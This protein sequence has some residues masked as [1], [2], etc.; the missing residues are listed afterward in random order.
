MKRLLEASL[1]T[2]VARTSPALSALAA[3]SLIAAPQAAFAQAAA[4]QAALAQAAVPSPV[5]R[6]LSA[7]TLSQITA[8]QSEANSRTPIQQ[9]IGTSL[10]FSE[11][12][13]RGLAVAPGI[14]RLRTDVTVDQAGLT[15]VDIDANVTPALLSALGRVGGKVVGSSVQFGQVR[16]WIPLSAVETLA[17]LAEVRSINP[18]VKWKLHNPGSVKGSVEATPRRASLRRATPH[19]HL[20]S[21]LAPNLFGISFLN[22]S[23]TNPVVNTFMG[24]GPIGSVVDEADTTHQADQARSMFNINGTGIKI[25]VIS[26]S[27]DNGNG[28]YQKALASGDVSAVTVIPGQD[29]GVASAEGLAMLECVYHLAPGAQLYFAT[30]TSGQGQFA[31]NILALQA[32]GCKVIVDDLGYSDESPFQDNG[33]A[34]AINTVTASGVDYFAADAN[35]G[36]LTDGTASGWEGDYNDA[37]HQAYGDGEVHKFDAAGDELNPIHLSASTSEV[38]F[39]WSDAVGQSANDY[40]LFIVDKNGNVVSSGQNRQTGTQN[41]YEMAT[42]RD[43]DS[44]VIIKNRGAARFLHIDLLEGHSTFGI[45]TNGRMRGHDAAENCFSIGATPAAAAQDSSSPSG[46][47][48]NPFTSSNVVETFTDDGPRHVFYAPDGTPVTPG[49]F[50]STGGKL[51]P[52]P[53]FTA[54]DGT[55]N[56]LTQAG[57]GVGK[58]PLSPFFG[59][60]C[61][62]PHAAAIAALVLSYNPTLTRTQLASVLASTCTDIMTPGFDTVSGPGILNAL[63]ALQ[64]TPA[65]NPALLSAVSAVRQPTAGQLLVTV[66]NTGGTFAYDVTLVASKIKWGGSS[67]SSISP[68]TVPILAFNSTT[69]FLLQF[70][71]TTTGTFITLNGTYSSRSFSGLT[72]VTP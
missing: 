58:E 21:L 68:A 70:P 38:D 65:P 43:G 51:L 17:S 16:A 11:K 37:G 13:A 5:P 28:L 47:Y 42:A 23:I 35:D 6:L 34:Q 56:T 53:E 62:A 60:S 46:P 48:P 18:A 7:K 14:S 4:P 49:N 41:P 59:T 8:L 3:F 44:A 30:G 32:A 52:K 67:P 63:A 25:G 72:R 66:K 24:S 36:N 1:T 69:T 61:A 29:G 50:S 15:L 2:F 57:V 22:T 40:D 27:L 26:D 9:K 64:A 39:F 20:P 31:Q 19:A 33:I 10:F 45:A 55:S 12:M 71:P 54:A